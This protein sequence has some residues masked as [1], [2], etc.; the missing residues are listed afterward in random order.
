MNITI[1]LQKLGGNYGQ[2]APGFIAYLEKKNINKPTAEH[3]LFFSHTA[4]NIWEKEVMVTIGAHTAKLKK[5]NLNFIRSPYTIVKMS[6]GIF[7][8]IRNN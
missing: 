7:R 6:F 3:P 4:E 2:S 5:Q 1:S 8:I